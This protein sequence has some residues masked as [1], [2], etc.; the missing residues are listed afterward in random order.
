VDH[1]CAAYVPSDAASCGVFPAPNITLTA[2]GAAAGASL[3]WSVI[4][5]GAKASIAG[6]SAGASV[7]VQGTAASAAQNDVT[8][9]V[10]DGRCTATRQLTVHEPSS[11]TMTQSPTSG[12]KFV[13]TLVRYTVKDQFGQAMGANICVDETVTVC[14]NN[15]PSVTFSFGDAPTNASG[16]VEDQ[17]RY[18]NTGGVPPNLCQKLDQVITAGGCGPLLHNT[19][20]YQASGITL[21]PGSSCKKGDPCP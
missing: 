16:Q 10:T 13:Q 15:R 4:R 3:Q 2:G 9:Q 14:A 12:P 5:G 19:I 17:L 20:L 18:S 1:Y 7:D 21:T 6:P 11:M 8:I